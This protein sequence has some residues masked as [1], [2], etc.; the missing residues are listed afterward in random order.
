M[1]LGVTQVVGEHRAVTRIGLL[2]Q[3]DETLQ[4][5]VLQRQVLGMLK[6]DVDEHP[7]DRLQLAIQPGGQALADQRLG[8]RIAGV[9]TRRVA[10]DHS[11][12][13]VEQQDQR[14][15]ALRRAGPV[16]QPAVQG[17]ANQA[18]ETDIRG[19][20][21]AGALAEPQAVALGG[22]VAGVQGVAEPPVEQRLPGRSRSHQ[23][24]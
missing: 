9:G 7:L 12:Q 15:P 13:L 23:P 2:V 11:R 18:T 22:D 6:D 1:A 21:L 4:R 3:V 20:V 19:F 16:G 10:E 17:L 5:L 24:W 8:A 14:Q